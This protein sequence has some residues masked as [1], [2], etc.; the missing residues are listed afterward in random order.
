MPAHFPFDPQT[1]N[2]SPC[3]ALKLKRLSNN[4]KVFINIVQH[5]EVPKFPISDPLLILANMRTFNKD[6]D[7]GLSVDVAVHESV[8]SMASSD[9]NGVIMKQVCL[10]AISMLEDKLQEP[11]DK[12]F[13]T[14]KTRN[15]YKGEEVLP[16]TIS[17]ADLSRGKMCL[18]AF[19]SKTAMVRRRSTVNVASSDSG[20]NTDEMSSLQPA[21]Q[22]SSV[23]DN[24]E[25]KI[26][27]DTVSSMKSEPVPEPA[28]LPIQHE[29]V[30]PVV[31]AAAEPDVVVPPT[32]PRHPEQDKWKKVLKVNELIVETGLVNKPNPIGMAY[33]RQLILTDT[34]R[35]FYIDPKTMDVKGE[36]EWTK[37]DPP[38]VYTVC[39]C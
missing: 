19:Q 7:E 9:A 8:W 6:N 20:F 16:L 33:K 1:L 15:N 39:I 21:K 36:V 38:L 12:D 4:Q 23:E 30:V 11:L 28:A 35:L 27:I 29:H 25:S 34:P 10:L 31:I 5:A 22:T 26:N 37:Q 14:P 32:R 13:K 3:V 2:P 18:G 17:G 24:N